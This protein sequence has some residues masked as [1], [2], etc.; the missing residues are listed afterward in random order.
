MNRE[1]ENTEKKN[2]VAVNQKD[3]EQFSVRLIETECK[4]LPEQQEH[5]SLH[6][7]LIAPNA[8]GH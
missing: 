5:L 8:F 7:M 6:N 1:S 4:Y 2:H 3:L